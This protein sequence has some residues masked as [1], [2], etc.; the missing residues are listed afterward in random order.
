MT[1]K[2]K[3]NENMRDQLDAFSSGGNI[4]DKSSSSFYCQY[5]SQYQS[6]V[7]LMVISHYGYNLYTNS[8]TIIIL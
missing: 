1:K 3:L 4:F 5:S 2:V 6:Q 8:H 7:F